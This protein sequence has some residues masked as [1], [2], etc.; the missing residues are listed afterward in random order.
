MIQNEMI[1]LA[2]IIEEEV[3]QFGGC[4]GGAIAPLTPLLCTAL[5]SMVEFYFSHL[6]NFVFSST[7]LIQS[8]SIS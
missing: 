2:R 4:M 7:L 3:W 8:V 5:I 1:V 6:Y